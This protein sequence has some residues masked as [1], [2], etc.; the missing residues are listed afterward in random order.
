MGRVIFLLTKTQQLFLAR[1]LES[2]TGNPASRIHLRLRQKLRSSPVQDSCGGGDKS[3]EEIIK[4]V[5]Q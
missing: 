4:M 2:A 3:I 5:V 1:A